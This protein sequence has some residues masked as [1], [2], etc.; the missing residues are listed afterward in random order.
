MMF[1]TCRTKLK[2]KRGVY[3]RNNGMQKLQS[4]TRSNILQAASAVHS[5]VLRD[6]PYFSLEQALHCSKPS[7]VDLS[8]LQTGQ[9]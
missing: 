1:D 7:A 4:C 6:L 3:C 5:V 9:D 8:I 2:G